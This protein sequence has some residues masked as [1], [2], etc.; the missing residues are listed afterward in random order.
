MKAFSLKEIY[1]PTGGH[2]KF[3]YE[4]HDYSNFGDNP[5][6]KCGGLRIKA[7][8]DYDKNELKEKRTFS[9]TTDNRWGETV[10]SGNIINEFRL[11]IERE[12]NYLEGGVDGVIVT[13][14]KAIELNSSSYT[15]LYSYGGDYIGYSEVT[16]SGGN[17]STK[18]KFYSISEFPNQYDA[19][20]LLSG[21]V[22]TGG[23]DP[24]STISEPPVPSYVPFYSGHWGKCYGRGLIKSV[25]TF[26]ASGSVVASE[27][28]EYEFEDKH[29][30]YGLEIVRNPYDYLTGDCPFL[31]FFVSSVPG[32]SYYLKLY[33][34]QTGQALLKSKHTKIFGTTGG[35]MTFDETYEYN[36][37]NQLIRTD[38]WRSDGRKL[39]TAYTYPPALTADELRD[40]MK[41]VSIRGLL[42]KTEKKIDDKIV[43]V[44]DVKYNRFSSNAFRPEVVRQL[45]TTSPITNGQSYNS[46]MKDKVNYTEY[47]NYGKV[48][49][50]TGKDKT[51]VVYLWSYNGQYPVAEI[52]NAS[53]QQVCTALGGEAWVNQLTDRTTPLSSDFIKIDGLRTALPRT[54]ITTYTYQPLVGVLT[55][56]DPRGFTTWY[57]YDSSGRLIETYYKENGVKKIMQQYE[58]NYSNN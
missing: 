29:K 40:H 34:H 51:K 47:N 36:N 39:T 12:S 54:S 58:Y 7:I 16:E 3:T 31:T 45:E 21:Y 32:T 19:R 33:Y 4:A 57:E 11:F 38:T 56:T 48:T 14:Q 41:G 52:T 25:D 20:H 27:T 35:F 49:E 53:Y 42:V 15:S 55:T 22:E 44:N 9:Y 50:L 2:T 37:Y 43:Q 8:E 1:Y 30:I 17:G 26:N 10:S 6:A 28:Y 23:F 24:N 46:L 18:Y 5:F 13:T